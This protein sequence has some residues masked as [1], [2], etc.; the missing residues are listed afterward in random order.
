MRHLSQKKQNNQ[1][2]QSTL[3]NRN[4]IISPMQNFL[5]RILFFSSEGRYSERDKLSWLLGLRYHML[6]GIIILT[7][8]GLRHDFLRPD[9]YILFFSVSTLAFITTITTYSLWRKEIKI[10]QNFI[11]GQ[12]IIDL[13]L[14]TGILISTGGM[15]NPFSAVF[16]IHAFVGG[17][18]L[19]FYPGLIFLV[20]V[21]LC[22]AYTQYLSLI[23]LGF[24]SSYQSLVFISQ[25]FVVIASW[26]MAQS[27]SRQLGFNQR[28]LEKLKTASE[29]INR[30]RAIGA[31]TAGL[32]HEFA[33]PLHTAKAR[34][35]RA[36]KRSSEENEDI[37]T[38]L[39]AIEE[40][41]Q[42]LKQMNSSQLDPR[43]YEYQEVE[44][45]GL[46]EEIVSIWKQDFSDITVEINIQATQLKIPI[47]NFTQSFI[48]T[49]DNAYEAMGTDKVI[50]IA[51]IQTQED[52][53][54]SIEDNGPGF[55]N[56]VLARFGEPFN[57]NKESGTGLGLYTT[58]LFMNSLGGSL[59]VMNKKIK[60]AI[61]EMRFPIS[62][63]QKV[64]V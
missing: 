13:V 63:C 38:A 53:I 14:F 51:S 22:T 35:E 27:I 8:L 54:V 16:Y 3:R 36:I 17:M 62:L 64:S 45:A 9:K 61:V 40:C 60:G 19:N 7:Y 52:F 44:I 49:L 32:S 42:I 18:L 24:S 23:H 12:L 55:S 48:N 47:L 39:I 33:S 59:T 4:L 31:L 21:I 10:T 58:L 26:T 20:F 28:K 6:L 50:H 1:L 43:N 2:K 46:V 29:R 41:S 25:Y 56:Q 5:N 57:T 11:A 30:L 37:K 34:L 15:N